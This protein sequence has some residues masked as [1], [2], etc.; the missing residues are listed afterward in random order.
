MEPTTFSALKAMQRLGYVVRRRVGKDR[1]KL[2]VFL[3]PKGRALKSRLV[4]LAEEVNNI[5]LRGVKAADVAATRALLL[6][7]IEN[8]AHDDDVLDRRMPSTRELARL[9]GPRR[10]RKIA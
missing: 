6:A 2:F 10:G 8:L 9:T 4:P 1:K 7:M 3:T 5:A